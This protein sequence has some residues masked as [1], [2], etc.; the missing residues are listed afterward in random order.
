CHHVRTRG[1]P[2]EMFVDLH[3]CVDS[4]LSIEA[5]HKVA[6]NVEE[7]IKNTI[8]GVEDVV[9]HIEPEDHCELAGP[10]RRI[11]K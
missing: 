9:V 3:I 4:S 2:G 8:E 1:M 5:A 6:G 10:T 11:G 7:T